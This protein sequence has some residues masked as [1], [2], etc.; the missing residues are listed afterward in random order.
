MGSKT[1]Q[2]Q[3][4]TGRLDNTNLVLSANL[5]RKVL[6][7]YKE[8]QV[9]SIWKRLFSIACGW[10]DAQNRDNGLVGARFRPGSLGFPP[11]IEA[12]GADTYFKAGFNDF[13]DLF[14]V[15]MR[16]LAPIHPPLRKLVDEFD[17][18]ILLAVLVLHETAAAGL[19]SNSLWVSAASRSSQS[20]LKT[21]VILARFT[22]D[23]ERADQHQEALSESFRNIEQQVLVN[24]ARFAANTLHSFTTRTRQ[25]AIELHQQGDYPSMRAGARDIVG[26]VLQYSRE[27]EGGRVFKTDYPFDTIYRWIRA[28]HRDC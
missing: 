14:L 27:Q 9:R 16:L 12:D 25:Y 17:Q 13:S 20:A 8:R 18:N 15:G 6:T 2:D 19:A 23:L 4:L 22:S 21:A 5:A 24:R 28:W 26:A 3:W 1:I 10:C 7:N 11:D